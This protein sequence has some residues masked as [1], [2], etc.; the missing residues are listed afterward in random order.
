MKKR[1]LVVCPGRGSYTKN[2][3]GYLSKRADFI[4]PELD[5]MNNYLQEKKAPTLCFGKKQCLEQRS[6]AKHLYRIVSK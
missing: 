3:L 5:L 2:E 1:I 6:D 4:K